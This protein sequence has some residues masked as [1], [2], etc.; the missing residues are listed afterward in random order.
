MKARWIYPRKA[1]VFLAA[2]VL[3]VCLIDDSTRVAVADPTS[4]T[5]PAA[6]EPSSEP[7][8]AR[9][10]LFRGALGPIFSRGMDRLAEKIER[11][12][13]K[14]DVYE[15]TVCSLVAAA[16]IEDYRKDP[17]PIILIGHSMGGRCALLFAEQLQVAGISASL[18]ATIDPAHMSPDVSLNVERFINIFLSKDVLGGGDIKP[19]QGFQGAYASYDLAERS[20]VSHISIDKMDTIHQQLITKILRIATMPANAEGGTIPLRYVVPPNEEIVLWDG[21]MAVTARS[22]D[23]LQALALRYQLP[24][25]SLMQINSVPDH[26]L[27]SAGERIVVPRNLER[28][29]TVSEPVQDMRVQTPKSEKTARSS[30]RDDYTLDRPQRRA[31]R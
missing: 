6:A 1:V 22:R 5:K 18:V 23:T 7:L 13:V 31:P 26:A 17:A 29:T 3:A 11:V 21:G 30:A 4:A 24:S 10:Y 14:A 25:W 12:G 8:R 9:V 16:A 20:E 15:F 19:A 28:L 2:A 27:L